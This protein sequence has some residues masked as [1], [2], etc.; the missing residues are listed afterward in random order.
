MAITKR[1]VFIASVVI[2]MW[3]G[4]MWIDEFYGGSI[5]FSVVCIDDVVCVDDA[6]KLYN[7]TDVQCINQDGTGNH[8]YIIRGR[9][10]QSHALLHCTDNCHTYEAMMQL[11]VLTVISIIPALIV[12]FMLVNGCIRGI[13]QYMPINQYRR[14]I[15]VPTAVMV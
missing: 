1:G 13:I 2:L 11:K 7:C 15:D 4:G 14:Q 9:T 12:L 5:S 8:T 10:D 6:L 3:I